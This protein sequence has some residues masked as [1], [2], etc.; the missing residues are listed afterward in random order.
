MKGVIKDEDSFEDYALVL[1]LFKITHISIIMT[2]Q[3]I[4][5]NKVLSKKQIKGYNHIFMLSD[6]LGNVC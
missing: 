2:K 1:V 3:R 4:L 6:L 5:T